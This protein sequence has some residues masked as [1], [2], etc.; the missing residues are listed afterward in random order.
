M[1]SPSWAD[2]HARFYGTR[3]GQRVLAAEVGL[4]LGNLPES[5][6]VASLG[7]GVGAH[8]AEMARRRPG[9]RII[10]LDPDPDMLRAVPAALPRTLGDAAALPFRDGALDA[11]VFVT[12]LE[13]M[14]RPD[15]ALAEVARALRAGGVAIAL[16]I[17]PGSEWGRARLGPR[18]TPWRTADALGRSLA[19]AMGGEYRSMH[20]LRIEG[21][22]AWP[23]ADPRE[24]VLLVAWAKKG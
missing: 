12:S 17:N 7:C 24:A 4:V 1:T 11:A 6:T 21:E 2:R 5:G 23:D 18:A 16:A 19:G 3:L 10:G 15:L 13:F 22:H 20:A 8:E 14:D 9:L